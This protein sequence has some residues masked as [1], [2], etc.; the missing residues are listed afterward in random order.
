MGGPITEQLLF[1]RHTESTESTETIY[2]N[3]DR[4]D[5]TDLWGPAEIT[6]MTDILVTE[7]CGVSPTNYILPLPQQCLYFLPLP[8]EHGS[9]LPGCFA[10]TIG[11]LG[12]ATGWL[13]C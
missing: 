1:Y 6:E 5:L 8:Q 3:T 13:P 4:T 2:S 9:F 10:L 11:M 12:P 7:G